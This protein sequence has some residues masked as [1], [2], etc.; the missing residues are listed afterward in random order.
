MGRQGLAA[1]TT[2]LE[3]LRASKRAKRV[4]D[5]MDFWIQMRMQGL[6]PD[7]RVGER[8][9]RRRHSHIIAAPSAGRQAGGRERASLTTCGGGACRRTR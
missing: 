4:D 3:S 7:A 8:A 5:L 9:R 2:L 1:A 6:E